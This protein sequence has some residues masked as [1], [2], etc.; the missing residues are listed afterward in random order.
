[1]SDEWNQAKSSDRWP[2]RRPA[3]TF[4]L[5]AVSAGVILLLFWVQYR[6][7][8]RPL[9]QWYFP[10]YLSAS[11]KA[12]IGF[13]TDKRRIV[14]LV[15]PRTHKQLLALPSGVEWAENQPP[16]Y[17]NPFVAAPA[18]A[19][20]GYSEVMLSAPESVDLKRYIT[21]LHQ[22]IY[23]DASWGDWLSVPVRGGL[24]FLLLGLFVTIP[25]DKERARIRRE[26]RRL[27]GPELVSAATFNRRNKSDGIGFITEEPMKFN[28]WL[29]RREG[30]MVR[31]PHR[32]ESSHFLLLGD[33]GAGKS[34]II[35]QMLIEIARRG[36]T[37]IVYDPGPEYINQFYSP[38]RG[39]II[40][41][42]LDVRSFKHALEM[43]RR[44]LIPTTPASPDPP[45]SKAR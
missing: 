31:I 13:K 43:L 15:N 12:S 3:W 9:E 4:N 1:M 37:A 45:P 32:K 39:D 7:W 22:E 19:A 29:L 36:E 6:W 2:G 28:E 8:W 25:K 16:G 18:A 11:L 17:E 38:E 42:P 33:T 24:T 23:Q 26:G 20:D 34:S 14:Y 35:R 27:R 21:I 30:H 40:L 44:D 10:K 41:N 5:I